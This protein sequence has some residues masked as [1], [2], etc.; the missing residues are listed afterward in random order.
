MEAPVIPCEMD[1]ASAHPASIFD[2]FRRQWFVGF[3][4][5]K[6][7][8]LELRIIGETRKYR[9][10]DLI[11]HKIL[12]AKIRSLLQNNHAETGGR[13]LLRHDP[14]RRARSDHHEIYDVRRLISHVPAS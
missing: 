3:G 13:Q 1:R 14:A 9:E 11:V 10:P 4:F 2:S 8:R 5:A 12:L 6:R 7:S